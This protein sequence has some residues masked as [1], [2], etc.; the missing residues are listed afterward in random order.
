[1]KKMVYKLG[2]YFKR[3]MVLDYYKEFV[4]NE[5]KSV[6]ELEMKQSESL[7]CL[8][9][10]CFS[11]VPYYQK[12]FKSIGVRKKDFKSI[13]DLEK[14]PI[15]TKSQIKRDPESFIP[16]NVK[17]NYINGSTGGSTGTPL[18]YRMSKE[19]YERGIAL[20]LKGWGRAGYK[21]GDRT[22]KIGGGSLVS[23]QKTLREKVQNFILNNRCYSSYGMDS[24]ILN[25]Y[26]L[27]IDRWKPVYLSGYASSLY[28]LAKHISEHNAN[29]TF[30]LKG[31]LS[32]AEVLTIKQRELIE[33]VFHVKVFDNYGL[34]DGG[35]SAYEC[36][37]HDGRHIDYERSIL[38]TVDDNGKVVVN[39]V[40]S[41]IATSL[42]NFA[43]PFIRY[44]TGDLGLVDTCGCACGSKRAL[45][46]S[47]Y[48]RVTD[49]LKLNNK[50][51]GSPVL[52]VLM[53][54]V[55]FE[56]YQII[57]KT[58]NEIDIKYIKDSPLSDLDKSF[59]KTSFSEHV[60]N[61]KMNFK[62]VKLG[63]FLMEN[64]HK[65][66]INEVCR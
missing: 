22:A 24:D 29:M 59:I 7:K 61:I 63:E 65:F 58:F 14:L 17:I 13:K 21:L 51:I 6:A 66:I 44:D 1:M 35:V 9:E 33:N 38:Q 54:K 62:K 45:L 18:K 12:L 32:T 48:G 20:Q 28:L 8:L 46:K 50:V 57:Q 16:T 4:L 39:K 19:C 23:N 5:S 10:F 31:I 41:I 53:G 3:P 2:C 36:S 55:D 42:Y 25:R 26:V 11:Y 52:T 40:G 47:V 56:H 60:G 37:V 49:Y 30:Y 34:N 43:M 15:L 27:E 64:K